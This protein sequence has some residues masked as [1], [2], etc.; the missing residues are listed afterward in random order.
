MK[1]KRFKTGVNPVPTQWHHDWLVK[2]T[3]WARTAAA[4]IRDARLARD[5]GDQE[6]AG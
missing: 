4:A 6:P 2:P 5:E 1:L 3:G